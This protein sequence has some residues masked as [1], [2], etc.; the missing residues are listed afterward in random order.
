MMV[1]SL[2]GMPAIRL[3]FSIATADDVAAIVD[4]RSAAA[5]RLTELHG[6]GHWSGG[7]SE[8]GVLFSM[9]QA[10]VWIARRGAAVVGTFRLATKKP[11]AIDKSYFAK[12][13]NPLYLTDM[14]VR[15]DLQGRGVGRRC[16][17][18]AFEATR[19]WPAD[20][21]RLDAYDADAGAG[22][23][24]AKLGFTEVGRVSYRGVPLVYFEYLEQPSFP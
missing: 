2:S 4:L 9:R 18:K 6:R 5:E 15:P 3:A 14:A 16:I 19:A 22:E 10:Q 11:W 17:A 21:I 8:R 1:Q 7:T 20:A 13:T 23:F 24:Y 12:S